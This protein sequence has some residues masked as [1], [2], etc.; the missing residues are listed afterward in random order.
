MLRKPFKDSGIYLPALG[1]GAMRL[2]HHPDD[3]GNDKAMTD[4]AMASGVNFFDTAYIYGQNGASELGLGE[5]LAKYPRESYYIS[6]KYM[7]RDDTRDYKAVFEEQLARLRTDYIDFYLIHGVTDDMYERYPGSGCIEYFAGLKKQGR[8]KYFGFSS[9]ASIETLEKLI[10]LHPSGPEGWDF[11]MLQLNYFDWVYGRAESEHGL[12]RKHDIPIMVMEPAR[13]GRLASLS[14]GAEALLRSARP[15]W[16]I[17]SWAFRWVKKLPGIQTVFSG[18]RTPG[19]LEEN[20]ILF[21]GG[22]TLTEEDE[23]LLFK[24]CEILRDEAGVLC[25]SCM[26]CI[27]DCPAR[28]NIPRMIE[29]YNFCRQNMAWDFRK[30]QKIESAE[31][32][33][34]NGKIADCSGCGACNGNCP[35]GIDVAE[36][37]QWLRN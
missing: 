28:I 3:P 29:I 19:Q 17:A 34:S 9:H 14:P 10:N 7:A 2:P 6:T 22:E 24:A 15:D 23:K 18:M 33:S 5:L 11:A 13:G 31:Q 21:S 32:E 16:S 8:I 1:M 12:L 4:Y 36:I 25:T 27:N 20:N 37:I 30:R 26:Y 35:Q